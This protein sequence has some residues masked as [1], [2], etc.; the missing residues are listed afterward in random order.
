M[1]IEQALHELISSI[2]NEHGM[3]MQYSFIPENNIYASDIC[4]SPFKEK[5]G[6]MIQGPITDI[7]FLHSTIEKYKVWFPDVI[8]CVSTW[9]DEDDVHIKQLMET[10]VI[11]IQSDK[12]A[13][14]GVYNLNLQLKTTHAGIC[15][16]KNKD[17]EYVLKTRTDQCLCSSMFL[18]YFYHLLQVF[19]L[20][21]N[22]RNQTNRIITMDLYTQKLVPFHL[23]DM[24]QFGH[25]TDLVSYWTVPFSQMNIQQNRL[26]KILPHLSIIEEQDY[27]FPEIYLSTHFA[28]KKLGDSYSYSLLA[29][30]QFLKERFIIVNSTDIGF[31]WPKK[32][33]NK[34]FM[35]PRHKLDYLSQLFTFFDWLY[36][37][38]GNATF[39]HNDE[40]DIMTLKRYVLE[41][42]NS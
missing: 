42:D 20:S 18:H 12:P 21:K 2:K 11:V 32:L 30:Y 24:M 36:I 35:F 3:Y 14:N 17:A 28:K 13:K 25:I 38:N 7:G 10:G 39:L 33:E 34:R 16:L 6:I 37:W 5:V 1:Q 41:Q 40:K 22:V 19:P 29:Y 4:L 9:N 23:S 31:L 8:I 15:A 26:E 27:D